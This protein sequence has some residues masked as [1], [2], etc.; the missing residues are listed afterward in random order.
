MKENVE[1]RIRTFTRR[2][3]LV[4][5]LIKSLLWQTSI[6]L[7]RTF[8]RACFSYFFQPFSLTLLWGDISKTNALLSKRVATT[9]QDIGQFFLPLFEAH[10]CLDSLKRNLDRTGCSVKDFGRSKIPASFP[11]L[12][13][14]SH[15]LEPATNDRFI[16]PTRV[17]NRNTGF[18]SSC[19]LAEPKTL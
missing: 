2:K 7:K 15:C 4:R 18:P 14:F 1:W 3:L 8:Y 9:W 16:V 19:P 17:A 13:S 11:G 10:F 6:S 5:L 12:S